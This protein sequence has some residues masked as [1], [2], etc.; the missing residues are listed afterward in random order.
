[1][2]RTTYDKNIS[3]LAEIVNHEIVKHEIVS[4]PLQQLRVLLSYW[5][6]CPHCKDDV[7]RGLNSAA[8]TTRGPSLWQYC[9]YCKDD[10]Q[11]GLN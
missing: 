9:L 7:Q 1:M 11:M 6:Y 10:V 5:Q 4:L 8:A 3:P 2:L